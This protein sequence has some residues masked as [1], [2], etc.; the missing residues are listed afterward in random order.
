MPDATDSL[1]YASI[2]FSDAGITELSGQRQTGFVP[3]DEIRS[4]LVDYGSISERPV[5]ELGYA[6][7]ALLISLI[8][9]ASSP[10]TSVFVFAVALWIAHHAVRFRYY[11]LVAARGHTR[12]LVFKGRID[13]AELATVLARS[14]AQFGYPVQSTTHRVSMRPF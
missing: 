7:G 10:V 3:R 11:L 8:S 4:V 5:R 6:G 14:S 13:S 9:W 12:R 2:L 1:R